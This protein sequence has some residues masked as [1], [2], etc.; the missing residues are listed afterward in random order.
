MTIDEDY[1]ATTPTGNEELIGNNNN[2]LRFL[3]ELT[4]KELEV[5]Y[6]PKVMLNVLEYCYYRKFV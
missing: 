6:L 2:I 1:C 4:L 3:K 5:F